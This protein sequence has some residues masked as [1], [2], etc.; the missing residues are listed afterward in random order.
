MVVRDKTG[1]RINCAQLLKSP[2][3]TARRLDLVDDISDIDDE[4]RIES[5]IAGPLTLIHTADGILVTATLETTAQL[6]CRRCLELFAAPIEVGI[7]EEFHPTVDIHTGAKLPVT[8]TEE[9]ATTIDEHH[10]LDLTEVVRQAIFL[11]IPMSAL[12]RSDCAGLCSICGQNL[13][14][15]QCQCEVEAVDPRLAALKEL[16]QPH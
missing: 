12:C 6:E 13:N 9:D 4:L 5:P 3:G 2:T 10:V 11:A 16:L 7:E 8:D 15:G 14:E 1:L